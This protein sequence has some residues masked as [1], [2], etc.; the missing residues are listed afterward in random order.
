MQ[1]TLYTTSKSELIRFS[2]GTALE[3][4]QDALHDAV[5]SR[6]KQLV[7]GSLP[8]WQAGLD[9]LPEL[10]IVRVD[11]EHE[12]GVAALTEQDVLADEQQRAT[13][14]SEEPHTYTLSDAASQLEP[15]LKQLMPWRKGPFRI[16]HVH[17]DTEWR[18]DWKWN[19]LSP[20]ISPLKNRTVLDVGC[21]NGYHLWRMRAQGAKTVFGIDP[22][23]L[24][25]MQFEAVQRYIQDDNVFTLPL[26]MDTLPQGMQLFDTVFSMGVLYHRKDPH[27]HLRE[28]GGALRPGGELVLET[29]V[30]LG[31]EPTAL[32]IEDR[33]ARM[34]NVWQLP[35]VPLLAKWLTDAG[36]E[37]VR[38]VSVD[39]TSRLEQ[40]QTEWMP[41][42]SLTESLNQEDMSLTVEGLPRPRR[43][44]MIAGLADPSNQP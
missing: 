12:A 22:S 40:R 14:E 2:T 31:E 19:R 41:Y 5:L 30:C 24:F 1:P 3:P 6:E 43:V 15:A 35:S 11:L 26:T 34:R 29:L 20:H 13:N 21:G 17:I 32:D 23:M 18:S 16:A 25:N 39:I 28:L 4:W 27:A 42:E 36:F 38:C 37:S 10:P 8:T 7:H 9:A 44:V 33:Y